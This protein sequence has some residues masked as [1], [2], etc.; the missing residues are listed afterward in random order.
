MRQLHAALATLEHGTLLGGELTRFTRLGTAERAALL[1]TL[2]ERGG[3]QAEIYRAVRDCCALAIYQQ[4]ATWP[5][6]DYGG[7]LVT[8]G[9][10]PDTY[11]SLL[12]GPGAAPR[13]IGPA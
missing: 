5:D 3:V 4:P 8:P 1:D 9:D 10:R 6:L 7:P 13:G 11:A 2:A 12:A